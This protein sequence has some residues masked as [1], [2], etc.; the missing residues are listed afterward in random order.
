MAG[1]EDESTI[2]R[3]QLSNIIEGKGESSDK[4][5]KYN[6]SEIDSEE[7]D[8]ADITKAMM[9]RFLSTL[10]KSKG[11]S[12]SKQSD[13]ISFT[14]EE[15]DEEDSQL[16]LGQKKGRSKKDGGKKTN[17]KKSDTDQ[18]SSKTKSKGKGKEKAPKEKAGQE[19]V[20]I[21][22]WTN[23]DICVL[24]DLFEE[25]PCLWDVYDNS[26]HLRDKRDIAYKEIE[27]EINVSVT[28]IKAKLAK[29]RSQLGREIAKT[30]KSKSGQGTDELYKPTWTYWDRLQFLR[31]VMQPGKSR[32]NLSGPD[33]LNDTPSSAEMTPDVDFSPE[34]EDMSQG[35]S[36]KSSMSARQTKRNMEQK[37]FEFLSTAVNALKEP[38]VKTD[39]NETNKSAPCHFSLYV[40]EKLSQFDKRT[41][42]LAEKKIS[43]I[44]FELEFNSSSAL[45][46]MMIP[47][48]NQGHNFGS[49]NNVSPAMAVSFNE[50]QN[51]MMQNANGSYL[52]M[53]Q[54]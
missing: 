28:E 23:E 54:R 1:S 36:Q 42:A 48:S 18:H 15:S 34:I 30:N 40:S 8:D 4:K 46:N 13:D 39:A 27:A 19:S 10:K 12:K 43:D 26:Y 24:I 25:R 33:F 17:Q 44:I 50:V 5:R 22:K 52:A 35:T 2:D 51:N 31:P 16:I 9:E 21:K 6:V 32:D 47:S 37:K 20:E 45:T 41:R 49:A 29:L 38:T 53:L 11:K 3:A 7:E 14:F